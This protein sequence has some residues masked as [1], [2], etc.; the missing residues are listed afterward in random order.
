VLPRIRL[1]VWP[2]IALGVAGIGLPGVWRWSAGF[3]AGCWFC[4]WVLIRD[5][6]PSHIEHWLDGAEGER[7]TAKALKPVES[8]GWVVAHD[9]QGRFGNVDHMVVG[10]NGVFL[11]DSK[12]WFGDVTVV[13]GVATV[14]PRDNP[15]AAWSWPRLSS[16]S[17]RQRGQQGGTPE[18]DRIRAWVQP[19]V[20]IW[21]PFEQGIAL[22]GGVAYVA[23]ER[24]AEWLLEQP[25]RLT[26]ERV[27]KLGSVIAG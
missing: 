7:W 4:F 15:D 16:A 2:L 17:R 9:L 5:Q 11:L 3:L 13:D 21:A 20:V 6:V 24:V 1:V 26:P 8:Q 18:A 19:V 10:P 25:H 27:V 22:S 12:N 14:T 23:G